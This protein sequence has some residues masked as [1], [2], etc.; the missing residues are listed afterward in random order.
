M[1]LE[2]IPVVQVDAD[3]ALSGNAEAVLREIAALLEQRVNTG[4]DAA[5]DLSSLPLTPADR[6][7]LMQ[8]LGHGEV[9]ATVEAS[10]RSVIRETGY[11]GVWWVE[12]HDE[13]GKLLAELIEVTACPVLLQT[14]PDD[15]R[16]GLQQL[17]DDNAA[18]CE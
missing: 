8:R 3:Q 5:I 17:I 2:H 4:E 15:L 9:E 10:G 16:A 18:P 12:H 6:V 13:S 11:H 1:R 14:H 7:W